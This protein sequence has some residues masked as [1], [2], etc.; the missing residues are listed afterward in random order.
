[1]IINQKRKKKMDRKA[2][3]TLSFLFVSVFFGCSE[4]L[5]GCQQD[6]L[7]DER[8]TISVFEKTAPSV[9]FITTKVI[10]RDF[11]S[12]DVFEIPQGSGSGFVWDEKGHIVT[13][14]HVVQGANIVNVTFSDHSTYQAEV[15]GVEP[16]KDLAVI[17]V[18][19]P[20]RILKTVPVG[21]SVNLRVG[22]KVMAIG[23]P[24]GLDQTLT[25]GVVSALGREITSVANR[26]IR[27]VIQTDAAI[28]P[29]NSG[30]PLIDSQGRLI[31]VNTA[32][33]APS[34]ANAGIGFAVPVDIV[35]SIV[36]QLIQYGKV[37]RPGMGISVVEDSIAQRLGIKGVIILNVSPGSAAN[38][39]GLK[40]LSRN[41]RG[42]FILGDVIVAVKGMEVENYDAL[43]Y[44][45]EQC[46]IGEMVSVEYIRDEKRQRTQVKLQQI[47]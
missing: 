11:F 20:S 24:F 26:K 6:L 36:P 34:G 3:V 41:Q 42:E 7:E 29:G 14:F 33:I 8:N 18:D 30:G 44:A 40:G 31:G 27:N 25:V 45:L 46:K 39:A 13:N 47:D 17:K 21:S 35:K 16:S 32:I 19:V 10:R 15:V 23:N 5:W 12:M 9:V 1:M 38:K 2:I 22:Q 4:I 43:A 28:N 37:I